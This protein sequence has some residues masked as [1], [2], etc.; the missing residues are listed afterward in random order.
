MNRDKY[1]KGKALRLLSSMVLLCGLFAAVTTVYAPGAASADV[2]RSGRQTGERGSAPTDA[3]AVTKAYVEQFY[4]LWLTYQQ[5]RLA[6]HNQLIGPDKISAVYQGVVAINDD[7]LYA[8]TPLDLT[9][10]CG[11]GCK[12]PE[13][14]ILTVPETEAGYSVLTLSPYGDIFD[15]LLPSKPSGTVTPQTVYALT[16]PG[17]SGD[18]PAG[19]TRINMPLSLMFLIYRIDKFSPSHVDQTQAATEFRAALQLQP[20]NG[21]LLNPSGGATNILPE[22]YFALPFKTIADGLIKTLPITYLRQLQTAV[23]SSNTPPLTPQEQALSAAFDKLFGARRNAAS[24]AAFRAG[25]RAAHAAILDDYLNNLGPNN[26]I[27]FTN[28]GDWKGN[29][30]DRSAI[31][32]FIQYGNGISTA[33]YYHTFKDAHGSPL[34]GSSPHGY[35]LTFPPPPGGQP[36]AERF[37]SVTAYTPQAIELIPNAA[38]KYLVASYTPGLVTNHDGSVSIYVSRTR[39]ASVPEANWLPVSNRP[40]NLML[41]V[42]GVQPGSSV[43]DNTYV[44][45]PVVKVP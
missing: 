10:S 20:L 34:V 11:P 12:V 41:R 8:S 36:P 27:H 42:Y 43:A 38:N 16:P 32:E 1:T 37:W 44:P 4:P 17:Y 13:P 5:S 14:A 25:A 35:V 7:T 26:W 45:P 22:F 40:F 15:S 24:R 9:A 21:Y 39:P 19:V 3:F 2:S 18:L 23:H 29:V 28:I 6:P 31:S 30:L 33:A